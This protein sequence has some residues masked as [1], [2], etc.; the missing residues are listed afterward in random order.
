MAIV[1]Q[2]G[3]K[4]EMTVALVLPEHQARALKWVVDY[5]ADNFAKFAESSTEGMRHRQALKDLVSELRSELEQ[6]LS[7]ADR[8]RDAFKTETKKS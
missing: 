6:V 1:N 4:V 3:T 7:R 8:A 2:Y 5:G